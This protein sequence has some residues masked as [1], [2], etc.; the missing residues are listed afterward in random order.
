VSCDFELEITPGATR[1]AYAV[2]VNSPAGASAGTVRLDVAALLGRRREL[3]ASVLASAVTTRA[4]LS[5]LE[6]PV[7][8]VG[9]ALFEGVF[10]GRVY[11]R[12]TA[13]VQEAARRGEPLRVV[14][15]LRAPEL[16]G[17]PWET[18]F[19]P[20]AGEYLCQREPVVRYVETAQPATPLAVDPPLRILGLVAAPRDL[21]RLD[22]AEERRRLADA[23]AD[24]HQR[25]RV[26]LVWAPAGSWPVLQE[27]LMA[28]PW[29]VLHFV[30]HG[31]TDPAG[32]GVL[33]LEDEATGNAALVSA[34]RFARLLHACRPVPRLV[35]LN[36]CQSGEAAADDLLSSTAATLVH[37][38]ISAAVAMQFAVTDPAALAFARGFYQA[39]ARNH[40]VDE[41]VRLG[42]IAIDG[43]GEQTL[44]WVTPVLYLRT[45]DTRLFTLIPRGLRRVTGRRSRAASA[46]G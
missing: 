44:E 7:R 38:G 20:E 17:L 33:A 13:S 21:P 23:V 22:V 31:G 5:G 43:T 4:G 3:A 35:V 18:L 1:G 30:G 26:E 10:A 9:R 15:R 6:R 8:E 14:L 24:L 28:G 37:S 25:R 45:A 29:H 12:Y 16:A 42:R 32:S 40:P 27:R 39:L 2:A 11:G 34:G 41:A 46:T 36:S 19:D